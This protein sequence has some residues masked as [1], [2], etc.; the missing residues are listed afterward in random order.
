MAAVATYT[1]D[2]ETAADYD[3]ASPEMF[4]PALLDPCY[5]V[6][7]LTTAIQLPSGSVT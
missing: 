6:V 3:A 1:W 2:A 4:D 5:V 7:L